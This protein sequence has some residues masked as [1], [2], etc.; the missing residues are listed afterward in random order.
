MKNPT[1][2]IEIYIGAD[3]NG[4]HCGDCPY[5]VVFGERATGYWS[6]CILFDEE[7]LSS[8]PDDKSGLVRLP[9]CIDADV[10]RRPAP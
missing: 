9:E 7:E 1:R 6:A 5:A 8:D 2:K 3:D 10:T 4:K